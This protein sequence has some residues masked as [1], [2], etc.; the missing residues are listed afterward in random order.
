M[1]NY[2][3]VEFICCKC[4]IIHIS[5]YIIAL[6]IP[7]NLALYDFDRF[8]EAIEEWN[9][10]NGEKAVI[11]GDLNTPKFI[12]NHQ[13]DGKTRTLN[14]F[15]SYFNYSQYNHVL[16][17]SSRLLDLVISN[18]VCIV[19]Q[20]SVPLVKIDDHHPALAI[21]LPNIRHH[22]KPFN[23]SEHVKVYKF[24]KADFVSLYDTL[25]NTDWSFLKTFNDVNL[26]LDGFYTKIYGILDTHVP[27]YKNHRRKFP[28]CYN[29]TMI[30]NVKEKAKYHKLWRR[31]NNSQCKH[32]Y[33]KL[34]SLVKRQIQNAD[35]N[36]LLDIQKSL[37]NDPTRFWSFVHQKNKTSHI[38]GNMKYQATNLDDPQSIVNAFAEFSRSIC[39]T[40]ITTTSVT[41][42]NLTLI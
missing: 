22:E 24:K 40:V 15:F 34:K 1:Q 7:P 33:R 18:T 20:D 26:A 16:N 31:T 12:L 36:Y 10:L 5:F 30:K 42:F 27:L 8:F 41:T 25:T 39:S 32:E 2:P 17:V 11:L 3:Y 9:E 13:G 37:K 21:K 28:Q 38:P 14:N 4:S 6:Y 19:E 23:T 35:R 29:S